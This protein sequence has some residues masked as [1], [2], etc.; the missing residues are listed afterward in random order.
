MPRTECSLTDRILDT[1]P[2]GRYGLVALLRI[3]EIEE[4]A[5]I[6]TAAVECKISPRLLINPSF[7]AAFAASPEK[8]MML[9]M[10]ELHHVLLGHT[11]L[12]PHAGAEPGFRCCD[13]CAAVPHVP[14]PGMYKLLYRFL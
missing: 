12:F 4:S 1:F 2:A 10:H 8:L 5:S 9:V 13:Q 6:E 3:L 7:I 14:R 11:T